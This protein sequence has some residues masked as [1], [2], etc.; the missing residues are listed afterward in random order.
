MYFTFI[1][2]LKK[3]PVEQCMT[4]NLDNLIIVYAR[5]RRRRRL[6]RHKLGFIRRP[7]PFSQ[8]RRWWTT[9]ATLCRHVHKSGVVAHLF[10]YEISSW[11][12]IGLAGADS[13]VLFSQSA[14]IQAKELK[15]AW[16]SL[17][18]RSLDESNYLN[19]SEAVKVAR[20]VK[21]QYQKFGSPKFLLTFVLF[22]QKLTLNQIAHCLTT[23]AHFTIFGARS[24]VRFVPFPTPSS[25]RTI[26]CIDLLSELI[27]LCFQQLCELLSA[28][29]FTKWLN[30]VKGA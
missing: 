11:L 12:E 19:Q 28:A 18:I 7:R 20:A 24:V 26:N 3:Q 4:P 5:N 2:E 21:H 27:N 9:V 10:G 25:L 14:V 22:H 16:H 15:H 29:F 1:H 23:L 30:S 6:F 17:G 8:T 13:E